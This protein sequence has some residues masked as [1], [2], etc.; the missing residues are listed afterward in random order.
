MNCPKC[1]HKFPDFRTHDGQ[2]INYCM[3]CKGSWFDKGELAYALATAKDHK[4]PE[5]PKSETTYKCPR[6]SDQILT[7][8]LCH[9]AHD[10]L[11]DVCKKCEGTFLDAREL[12]KA[13]KIAAADESGHFRLYRAMQRLKDAPPSTQTDE[14]ISP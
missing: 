1:A 14:Q 7:E 2:T 11:I 9:P 8:V 12:G 6:C 4:A 5:K 10:L 13:E 3:N